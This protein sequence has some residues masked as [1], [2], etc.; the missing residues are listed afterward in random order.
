MKKSFGSYFSLEIPNNRFKSYYYPNAIKLNTARNALEYLIKALGIEKI[1]LPRLLCDAIYTPIERQNILYDFYEVDKDLNP[2]FNFSNF[3]KDSYFLYINYYGIKNEVVNELASRI[4]NLI[5]DNSQAFFCEPEKNIPTFYSLRKFFGVADGS[6]LINCPQKIELSRDKSA[7]R[8]NYLL[9]RLENEV[10][11]AYD[12]YRRVEEELNNTALLQ[13]SCITEKIYSAIDFNLHLEARD[14]NFDFL[15][16][17]LESL[18]SLAINNFKGPLS[19][20]L[21]LKHG[22]QIRDKLRQERIYLPLFWPNVLQEVDENST[23][24]F[25]AKNTLPIPVDLRY[26]QNDLEYVADRIISI[27]QQIKNYK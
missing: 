21:L 8:M 1:F 27:D 26:S 14:S 3:E 4:K 11:Y 7:H 24:Y 15:H 5:I 10:E 16:S 2:I 13:M 17:K 23:E 12:E 20:P 19:Y 6:L 9:Q 22:G 18:N 25:I